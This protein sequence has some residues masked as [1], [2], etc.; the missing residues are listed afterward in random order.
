MEKRLEGSGGR[1]SM[2][3]KFF[4]L[5][6][7]LSSLTTPAEIFGRL[8][9]RPALIAVL[10]FGDSS[11]ARRASETTSANLGS[12][13]ELSILDRDQVR[14][15]ARGAGYS[16][17]LNMSLGE[18]RSL[19]AAIGCDYYFL[20]DAQTLRRSPSTGPIYFESYATIFL[21]SARTG[22]LVSWQRPSFH[23]LTA[24]AAEKLLL[25]GLSGGAN[26]LRHLISIRRAREDERLG[27]VTAIDNATPVIE[28]APDDHQATEAQ[29]L[30]LPRPFR[31]LVPPYP[32]T[33]A[34]AEVEATVDVLADLDANG[35]VGQVEIARWAG[36]GLD[37]ATIQTVKQLHFFPALRNGTRIPMR[38]LLRYNFR[39]PAK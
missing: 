26:R 30:R 38:V 22:R 11:V 13:S 1:R 10:D 18:A 24:N 28:A 27:R 25:E 19:G 5:V 20:G 35:E 3:L 29:G 17:S 21:V 33:A 31:R 4:V 16:A 6:L 7:F 34:N 14:S 15:A 23:A 32:E 8:Q 37:E 9:E 12:S 36:F 39:K 2:F